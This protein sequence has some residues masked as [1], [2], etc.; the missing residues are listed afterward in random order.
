MFLLFSEVFMT[1]RKVKNIIAFALKLLAQ[2]CKI[3][4]AWR[5]SAL[6]SQSS[7]LQKNAT[8]PVLSA[9]SGVSILY[10]NAI[11]NLKCS[12]ANTDSLVSPV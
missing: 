7:S 8:F 4:Y 6:S 11:G 10:V 3:V 12:A 5:N 1:V 9:T 2:H